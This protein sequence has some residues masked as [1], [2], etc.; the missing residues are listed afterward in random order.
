VLTSSTARS[1]GAVRDIAVARTKIMP[2][3]SREC[4][5]CGGTM[6]LTEKDSVVLVPGNPLSTTRRSREWIC[7]DCDYFEDAEEE[8]V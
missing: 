3:P 1:A 8:G 2:A 5:M 4:P 6:K 7:P